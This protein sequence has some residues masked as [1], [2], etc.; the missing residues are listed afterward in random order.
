MSERESFLNGV[1]VGELW[2]AI[3]TELAKKANI[4]DLDNYTTPDAVASAIVAALADYPDNTTVQTTIENA[5][6]EYMTTS[7]IAN[8]IGSTV[9]AAIAGSGHIKFSLVDTLPDSGEDN[10]IYLVPNGE[11][12]GNVKDEYMWVN[13][14][15]EVLGSTSVDLANYWSKDELAIMTAEELKAILV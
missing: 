3:K 8:L 4:S 13:E 11:T 15:W 10:I 6:A 7:E 5:L 14:K 2:T 12:S 1:R 9:S